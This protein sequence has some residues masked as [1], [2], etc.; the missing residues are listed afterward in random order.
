MRFFFQR[1]SGFIRWMRGTIWI[2]GRL[3]EDRM[4]GKCPEPGGTET[5]LPS[6]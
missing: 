1:W 3:R 6:T 5:G 4:A 2:L